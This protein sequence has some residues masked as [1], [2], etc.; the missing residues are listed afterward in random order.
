MLLLW[1]LGP[2][3]FR[4]P[5]KTFYTQALIDS[6]SAVNLI[7]HHFVEELSL[8]TILC[9]TPLRVTVIDNRSIGKG[10]L[11]QQTLPLTL[12]LDLRSAYN[13]VRIR[14]RDEWKMAF[15]TTKGHYE[16]L[17]MPYGLTNAPAVFQA[18]I[19]EVFKDLIDRHV[20]AL[21]DDIL[22]YSRS[23]EDHVCQILIV[24]TT[25]TVPMVWGALQCALPWTTGLNRARKSGNVHMSAS[26]EPYEDRGSKPIAIDACSLITSDW[27]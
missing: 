27:S 4:V 2:V 10:Y 15:H 21:I 9:V 20:I 11:T 13:L 3:G 25:T 7:D 22:I 1:G 23:Y 18:F 8:S 17:V 24:L 6:G 12:Q 14:E 26:K 5:T 16:Y 19:N